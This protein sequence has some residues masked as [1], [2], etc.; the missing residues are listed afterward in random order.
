MSP[1]RGPATETPASNTTVPQTI[2]SPLLQVNFTV[3]PD[4]SPLAVTRIFQWK[5]QP[6]VSVWDNLDS[7][8]RYV[9][10]IEEHNLYSQ[11]VQTLE[12]SGPPPALSAIRAVADLL[13]I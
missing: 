1:A 7:F 3:P 12:G 8:L 9:A 6:P 10:Q 11:R 2:T 4:A 13:A 5:F